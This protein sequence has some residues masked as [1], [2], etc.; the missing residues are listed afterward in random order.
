MSNKVFWVARQRDLMDCGPTCLQMIAR[1][2][3]RYLRLEQLR[4]RS[5]ITRTGVSLLGISEAAE[6]L[7]FHTIGGKVC[8]V[9]LLEE[10]VLPCIAHW[11][12]NHFVVIYDI[13]KI[14]GDS[15]QIFVADPAL[16]KVTYNHQE[17]EQCWHSSIEDGVSYGIV[18]LLEPTPAFYE[19]K[20]E[21][22]NHGIKHGWTHFL[23]YL[24]PYRR[25]I[26]HV[27]LSLLVASLL[28]I[29]F[30]F[31]TQSLVD[32]GIRTGNLNFIS[33]ILIAQL[34]LFVARIS[35][36]FIRS[37]LMLHI[38]Y[39]VNIAF[40]SGYL[41]KLMR[42]PIRFFDSKNIG[43]IIQRIQ[44]NERIQNFL[45]GSLV[46]T[47]FSFLTFVIFTFIL[48]IYNLWILLI[49]V[50]GNALYVLWVVFFMRYR[51]E[52]DHKRFAMAS[53]EQ[54]NLYQLIV[55]MQDIK[56]NN[57]EQEKRWEWERI[58]IKL[59]R[60]GIKSLA[61]GQIQQLGTIF[62]SQFTNI[63][64][65]YIAA[66]SVVS[67]DMSLG[68]MMSLTY[69]VGQLSAPVEQFIHF[70]Q[71][72]QDATMSIDRLNEIHQQSDEVVLSDNRGNYCTE[73]PQDRGLHLTDVSFSYTG[74][75]RDHVIENIN[76]HIPENQVTAIVGSSGSGKTTIL[77]L[78]LGFYPVN[79]GEIRV[80]A[81]P[82]DALNAAWWRSCIGAVMQD[83][84]IFSD[85]IV[86]NIALDEQVD[87]VRLRRAI[88][89]A[90]LEDYIEKLPLGLNTKIGQEGNGL[91]QGQKQRI[92]IARAIYKEPDYILLDEATN[93]LD[94]N[95]ERA[96]MQGLRE[97]Y[98]G[99][100]V[101][102]VAHRLSTVK[103]ADK[104]VV[105]DAGRIVEEGTHESLTALRGKYY[106]LVKNQLELGL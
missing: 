47:L 99:R 90:C 53:N 31:L 27:G 34:I 65:S 23:Y 45:T 80:G 36:E 66:R 29:A 44:D 70:A 85:T 91:S 76:L 61:L 57:C 96:I 10:G 103:D 18:L 9:D 35:A 2:Y 68:M 38:S 69:I 52:L 42:L 25:D 28:Q 16:G 20:D 72:L 37:W 1:H 4:E 51:K 78:L 75:N 43:D 30:P 6:E 49:F 102:V 48:G 14:K 67:G 17:F 32:I 88:E 77:K 15:Y 95:N 93:A 46:T 105:L 62:F 5:F 7:G 56:L 92:L 81:I 86:R 8:L 11:N 74:E 19:Q 26:V 89:L 40:L 60:I 63:V 54:S 106:E 84:F 39:R 21:T 83:G 98:K 22:I 59:Y 3:G 64:I 24:S 50:V 101:V 33:L 55:G 79:N 104:I 13:K 58:Q 41:V 71:G 100:T 97:F 82:L 87:K 73:L 94:A 12:G